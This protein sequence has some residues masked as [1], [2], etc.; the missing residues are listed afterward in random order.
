MIN[1][2]VC[3]FLSAFL[4]FQ[5][6][7]IISKTLLPWFGGTQAV[8]SSAMLF[9]EVAL[10]GG[11]AYANWLVRRRTSRKQ[12]LIHLSLM[13]IS[14]CL[15]IFLWVIW[16]SPITPAADL[17]PQTG[18]APLLYILF[19]LTISVGLPFFVLSTNSPL[20]Q[21]WFS[22]KNPGRS[23]YW[24]YALSNIG[25]LIGLILYP[26]VVEPLLT[27]Q[28]QGWIW[29]GGYLLF[30]LIAGY[31]AIQLKNIAPAP[32]SAGSDPLPT[33]T[34]KLTRG[35]QTLWIVLSATASLMFLAV[36]NEITQ[37][38]AVIPFLWVLPLGIY[39]FSF[40]LAFSS[41]RWYQR[42]LYTLL[43]LI[44]IGA[45][46]YILLNPATNYILQVIVYNFL[47]FTITMICHGELYALRPQPAH[48][49]R[50]YL[51]VSIG[52]AIG[53]IIVNLVA[54][55]IF[56]GYWEFKIGLA[57]VGIMLAVL[58]FPRTR[59][60]SAA[61]YRGVVG[62]M[63]LVV[64]FSVVYLIFF[65]T[66]KDLFARR[67][68]YGVVNVLQKELGVDQQKAN[69]LV[70]GTTVHGLQYLDAG[71][72][73]TP[74]GYYTWDS[75]AGLAL[76]S[77]PRYGAG[78]RV[79]VLGLGVGTLAAYGRPGDYYCFYEINPVI[80]DLATGQGGYFSYIEDSPADID[81]VLGD[82]RISLEN[83]LKA[84]V[85][86]DF[87]ILVLDTFSS[88]SIPAHLVT[89]EAF[90]IYLQNLAPDGM[91]AAHISNK[92]L[93]LK[94]VLWQVAQFYD[95]EFALVNKLP[96]AGNPAAYPSEWILLT[97]NAALLRA[98]ALVNTADRMQGYTTTIRLWTDDFSNL[99]QI[100]K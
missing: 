4:L 31:N 37:E 100:I 95:L 51:L 19:L 92:H 55:Y 46:I 57:F 28:R 91:I 17:K 36:T 44:T 98:P 59:T 27:I 21:A 7:P 79:G 96:E 68:F 3:I 73:D 11:Y 88:D 47:L 39:L 64:V 54:P 14:V 26:V 49:T 12:T 30:V 32:E 22:L 83:E 85:E 89:R 70:H 38:V 86:N 5:I 61:V 29:A 52:G 23:P 42:K 43:F 72:R 41:R 99:F 1:F 94:P 60:R 15:V 93:D 71:L 40:V 97:R 78:M 75:G 80:V 77:N 48:L 90:A 66:S 62:L 76:L 25:S 84:G 13:A 53:G 65:S 69:L 9:F 18:T 16:P 74:I 20:M 33:V 67:N 50:F 82:A 58:S 10:T 34:Q 6:Q 63:A 56:S 81:I 87:D 35:S 45:L 2:A 8:W 24:L